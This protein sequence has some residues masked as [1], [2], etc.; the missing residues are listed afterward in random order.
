MPNSRGH[1]GAAE[2]IVGREPR[3]RV[4]H[5]ALLNSQLALPRGRVNSAVRC[6]FFTM[7][8]TFGTFVISRPDEITNVRWVQD[9]LELTEA[10]NA[11]EGVAESDKLEQLNRMVSDSEDHFL[12]PVTSGFA[13]E[14]ELFRVA[15]SFRDSLA[16]A[17]N[18]RVSKLASDWADSESWRDTSVNPFDLYGMLHSLNAVCARARAEDKELYL[19]LTN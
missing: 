3:E 4:S 11:T 12:L 18:A 10:G 17:D 14:S 6:F 7:K 16:T 13:E 9:L 15:R 1:N 5:E 2:Q 8:F 19:L